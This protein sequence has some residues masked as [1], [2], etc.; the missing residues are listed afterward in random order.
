M[1]VLQRLMSNRQRP[2]QEAEDETPEA[3]AQPEEE[4]EP[5]ELDGQQYQLPKPLAEKLKELKN[6][7]LRQ[8]DYTRKTQE[9]A[10]SRKQLERLTAE[11]AKYAEQAK[12]LAPAYAQLQTMANRAQA[13]RQALTPELRTNDPIEFNTLASEYAVLV[14]E[15][16]VANSQVGQYQSQLEQQQAQIRQQ[17]MAERLPALFKEVPELAKEEVRNSL[18]KYAR[19]QGLPDSAIAEISY[20]PEAVKLL[21]KAQMYDQMMS[22]QAEA[23]KSLKAKVQA[24]PPVKKGAA[25]PTDAKTQDMK[26]WKKT[27]AKFTDIPTS[28]LPKF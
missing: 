8:D 6:S 5:L 15:I 19:D 2:Q 12:Q 4:F 27:G 26:A 25:V 11:A 10:E 9:V 20:M 22:K 23:S 1:G 24:L 14:N 7:G 13:I 16:N 17:M 18:G 3:E 28:L 21:Y